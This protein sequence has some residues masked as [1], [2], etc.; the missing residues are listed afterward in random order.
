[1]KNVGFVDKEGEYYVCKLTN[2]LK[3]KGVGWEKKEAIRNTISQIVTSPKE[4]EFRLFDI[5]T[6]DVIYL[7]EHNGKLMFKDKKEK[8]EEV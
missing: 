2:P 8:N 6:L 1:M 4:R 5:T 3:A 7:L